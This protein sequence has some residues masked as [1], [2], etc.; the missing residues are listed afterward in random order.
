MLSRHRHHCSR[1]RGAALVEAA[2]VLPIFFMVVLGIIEFGR[3]M[4]VSQ[5]ITNAAREGARLAIV[6]GQTNTSV[7]QSIDSFMLES[8]N[9]AATDVTVTITIT[10]AAGNPPALNQVASANSRDL[11]AVDVQVPFD[12]VSFI[13]GDYLNGRML[14]GIASMR[15]E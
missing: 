13:P 11:I 10:E 9:V 15:H 6:D 12:K 4:M 2:I 1:R 7:E 5:L 8:A 14:R 3:A